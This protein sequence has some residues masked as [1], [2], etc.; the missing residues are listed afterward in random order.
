MKKFNTLFFIW[1][2]CFVASTFCIYLTF[3]EG[4]LME[5]IAWMTSSVSLASLI[6]YHLYVTQKRDTHDLPNR[7]KPPSN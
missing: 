6:T 1:C 5:T 7:S 4:N 3:N 2:F